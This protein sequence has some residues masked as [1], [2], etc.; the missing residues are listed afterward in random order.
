MSS[1]V[2]GTYLQ[3]VR[4]GK[5]SVG[6]TFITVHGGGHKR[7]LVVVVLVVFILIACG[8][9]WYVIIFVHVLGYA[10]SL[11]CVSGVICMHYHSCVLLFA[12]VVVPSSCDIGGASHQ[13]R[14]S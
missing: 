3:S 10:C 14:G 8:S 6:T 9:L 1:E 2:G 5:E 12:C 13:P 4:W 11:S 7:G